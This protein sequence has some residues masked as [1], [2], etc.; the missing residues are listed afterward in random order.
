MKL[1]RRLLT[2]SIL[3]VLLGSLVIAG[4]VFKIPVLKSV[5][6]GYAS[7]KLNTAICFVLSGVIF[8]L[9]LRNKYRAVYL[10][11]SGVLIVFCIASIFQ[12][13]SNYNLGIDEFWMSDNSISVPHNPHPGRMS[14]VTALCFSL[15]GLSFFFLSSKTLKTTGQYIL[16]IVSLIAFIAIVGY[17]FDIPA[18]YKLSFLSSMAVHTS[19]AL[20]SFSVA[21]SLVN[22]Y[23][24]ITGLFSRDKIGNRMA[25]RMFPQLIIA[26]FVLGFLL[27]YSYR[28]RIVGVE[29]G[30]ALYA[31]SFT[32]V[33]FYLIWDSALLLNKIDQQREK[34]ER[35]LISIN[36]NLE[37]MVSMRTVE[38]SESTA[39]SRAAEANLRAVFDSASVSIIEADMDGVI[40]NF[41]RGAELQ[42]GYAAEEVVNKLRPPFFHL[43]KEITERGNELT[44]LFGREIKG[45]DVFIEYAKHGTHESKKWT[46]VRK[47]GSTFPVQLVVSPITDDQG[48]AT[49]FLGVATDISDLENAKSDLEVLA[50][51]LQKQ[52]NQ[53]LNFARI[54]SHN[55]RSPVSN[56]NTILYLYKE[57]EGDEKETLF[58]HF[59]AVIHHLTETLDQLVDSL[60]I[61]E[62]PGRDSEW[63]NFE[64]IF[65]KTKQ[66][67][68]GAIIETQAIVTADFSSADKI[69]YPKSYLESIMLNLLSNAMKYRSPRRIPNIHFQTAYR[70]GE[71]IMKVSDNG[72]GIDLKKHGNS[73]FGLNK[74]FHEHA[75][76][77]GVGLY[78]TKK[79]IEAMGGYITAES[80]VE[81]GTTFNVF[82]NKN[83]K[84]A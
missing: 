45:N 35:N 25:R 55:L 51:R 4:W 13:I 54:T 6:P 15:L 18:L 63:V 22:P 59:E 16:H 21:V 24:G 10:T 23:I 82:F 84:N 26:V 81:K 39:K 19:L 3:T 40:T 43:E 41:N 47:D 38:L 20:F 1:K 28:L 27:L 62:D 67:L 57:S 12:D 48:I 70:N 79:Q 73:L 68:A 76:A 33:G 78:I 32:L 52:N 58:E 80:E 2:I 74:T 11:L 60:K 61:Q 37:K 30:I 56:L 71:T 46:Y 83:K 69:E 64:D 75:E 29:F 44:K 36:V 72:L 34:A 66:I 8:N 50:T 49:G 17:L 77:K 31:V 42:L 5:F 53:L 14:T 9:Y 65:N 7:M